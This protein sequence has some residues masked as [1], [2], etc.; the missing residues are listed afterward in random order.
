MAVY[1]IGQVI[2]N[3]RIQKGI[4]QEE[5]AYPVIDRATLSKIENGRATPN[6]QT[7]QFLFERLGIPKIE[8][9]LDFFIIQSE[10]QIKI[11]K[12]V[13]EIRDLLRFGPMEV[14]KENTLKNIKRIDK[15]LKELEQ[16]QKYVSNI[17]NAQFIK[18]SHIQNEKLKIF[19]NQDSL[20]QEKDIEKEWLDVIK[21]TIPHYDEND[22]ENY[23]L[24]I[25]EISAISSSVKFHDENS[26]FEKSIKI[27]NKL[28]I[29]I[30]KNFIENNF[31]NN[32]IYSSIL[33]GLA[34][35]LYYNNDFEEALEICNQGQKFCKNVFTYVH[36]FYF[37]T[38]KTMVYLK[39]NDVKKYKSLLLK[40]YLVY[41]LL[42][43]PVEKAKIKWF[44]LENLK[45]EFFNNIMEQIEN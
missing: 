28:K 24:S 5:L 29:N 40:L 38:I 14:N 33:L 15:I 42:E 44:I 41:D 1:N 32:T 20:Y 37:L 19:Y 39:M 25:N 35:Y 9:Y 10:E 3:L 22:I 4:S 34:T 30:E 31:E 43:I 13:Q 36:Y 17:I 27:Y 45:K 23:F 26:N 16:N 2:K 18:I 6:K 8:K 7:T 12:K 11:N 21:M